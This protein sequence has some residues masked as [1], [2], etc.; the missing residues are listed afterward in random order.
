MQQSKVTIAGDS[1]IIIEA[2][3]NVGAFDAAARGRYPMVKI[4]KVIFVSNDNTCLGPVAESIFNQIGAEYGVEAISRGLVVLFPEP[5]NAK[6]RSIME[7]HHLE[8]ARELSSQLSEED[9]TE[10]TLLLAMTDE[11][12]EQVL[13]S[14]PEARVQKLR[15]FVG[16][17]GNIEI[18]LGG[19]LDDYEACYEHMDLLTKMAAQIIF[20]EGAR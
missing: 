11:D 12:V 20:K 17:K 2:W 13:E 9:I 15:S 3:S 4:K 7:A 18:P 6:M 19:S 14:F 10:D 16:Q 1:A 8:P 5:M